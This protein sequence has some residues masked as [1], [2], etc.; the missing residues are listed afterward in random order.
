MIGYRCYRCGLVGV[1]HEGG[2]TDVEGRGWA[3][4]PLGAV[5]IDCLDIVGRTQEEDPV[6]AELNQR[7]TTELLDGRDQKE[8]G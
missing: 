1:F 8:G 2:F 6:W 3:L 5:H 7:M 4:A